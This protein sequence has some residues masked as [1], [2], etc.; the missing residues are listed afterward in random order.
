MLKQI[1][2]TFVYP[3][4]KNHRT[5]T[6]KRFFQILTQPNVYPAVA[7]DVCRNDLGDIMGGAPGVVGVPELGLQVILLLLVSSST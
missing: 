1:S 7:G 4:T 3:K 5:L 6:Q 2:L